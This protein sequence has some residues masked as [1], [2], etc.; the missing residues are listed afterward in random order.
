MRA[1]QEAAKVESTGRTRRA[2][3]VEQQMA[4]L[5]TLKSRAAQ[6]FPVDSAAN[7]ELSA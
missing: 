6:L 1:A 2:G 7:E 5:E 4:V 3:E